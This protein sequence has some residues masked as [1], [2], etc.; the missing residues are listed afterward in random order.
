MVTA[1]LILIAND[2]E[3]KLTTSILGFGTL[4]GVAGL[5]LFALVIGT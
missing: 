5:C 3:P 1:A 4:V 2:I